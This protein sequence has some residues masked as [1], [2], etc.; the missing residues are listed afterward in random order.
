M[1]GISLI[2]LILALVVILGALYLTAWWFCAVQRNNKQGHYILED[3]ELAASG[4]PTKLYTGLDIVDE[5][6]DS[7][8]KNP[9]E[10]D[11]VNENKEVKKSEEDLPSAPQEA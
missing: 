3:D 8:V 2:V 6:K 5:S 1:D 10:L 11:A 4:Y 9:L 7:Y